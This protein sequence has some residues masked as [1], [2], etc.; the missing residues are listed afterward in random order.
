MAVYDASQITEDFQLVTRSGSSAGEQHMVNGLIINL[1]GV[2]QGDE[3]SAEMEFLLAPAVGDGEVIDNQVL[4][5]AFPGADSQRVILGDVGLAHQS[6]T[7]LPGDGIPVFS[8]EIRVMKTSCLRK[9]A[10]WLLLIISTGSI[11]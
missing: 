1:Y 10:F 8:R 11:S 2:R 4:A 3:K 9:E 6:V 7:N 5:F